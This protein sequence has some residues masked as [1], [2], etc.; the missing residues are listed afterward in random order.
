MTPLDPSTLT[1]ASIICWLL[2]SLFFGFAPARGLPRR[3]A[4][5][6]LLTGL[7]LMAALLTS[8]WLS[9][10]RAPMRTL[11]ETRLW[12]GFFLPAIGYAV[13]LRWGYTWMIHYASLVATAFLLVNLLHPE[14]YDRDLMPALQSPWFVPHVVVYLFAYAVLAASAIVAIKGLLRHA[15]HRPVSGE[16]ALADR[17][18][19]LGFGFLSLGLLFGALWGKEAWGHYWTW[20]PKETWAFLTWIM[21]LAYIH[22]RIHRGRR[23]LASLWVLAFAFGILLIAWFGVNYLP[24]A[25]NSVHTYAR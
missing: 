13:Y 1:L 10:G 12:Y 23:E 4:H 21:Y 25:A 2:A 18:V 7:L 15:L 16:L 6:L 9:M 5:L 8:L 24:S 20:D 3:I 11:G 14:N 22:L 19:T 17:L